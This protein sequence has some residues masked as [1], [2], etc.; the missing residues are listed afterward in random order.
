MGVLKILA[1]LST[2]GGAV[3][4]GLV[5]WSLGGPAEAYAI[6]R[7][8]GWDFIP[9]MPMYGTCYPPGFTNQRYREVSGGDTSDAVRSRLGEPLQILWVLDDRPMGKFVWFEP[10][11]GGRW[12]STFVHELDIPN[13]TPMSTV[14]AF[15]S[16]IVEEEWIYSRSCLPDDSKRIRRVSFRA[17]RV[18]GRGSGI[19]YD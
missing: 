19:Y 9:L 6:A 16:Q 17:G 8:D 10:D 1:L 4:A 3:L 11:A 7:L 15:H 14:S 5:S 13:G 12:R 18:S 2:I